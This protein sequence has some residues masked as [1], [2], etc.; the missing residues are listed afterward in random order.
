[1]LR[2]LGCVRARPSHRFMFKAREPA[3]AG[4][5]PTLMQAGN[6]FVTPADSDF[7]HILIGAYSSAAVP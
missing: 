2:T 5:A 7:D 1:V 4:V 3:L 6:W